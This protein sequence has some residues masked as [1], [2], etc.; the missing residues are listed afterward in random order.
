MRVQD[1]YGWEVETADGRVIRQY[2]GDGTGTPSTEIPKEGIVRAS[3]VPRLALLPQHDILL[4]SSKGERFVRWFGR[5][6]IK[7]PD[8]QG[9]R[10]S[11]Y[12]HCIV[13]GNYRLWVMSSSGRA[14]V[15]NPEYEVYL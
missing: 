3:L 5:G 6:F 7:N 2:N 1:R 13:T 9:Y 11:E 12:A 15:T 8:G 10:V 4:D 14:L